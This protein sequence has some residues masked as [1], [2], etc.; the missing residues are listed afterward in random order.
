[1]P[2][3]SNLAKP[4]ATVL[5]TD[6]IFNSSEGFTSGNKFYSVNPAARWR[7]FPSRHNKEGGVLNFVD[8]HSAYYRQSKIKDQQ[9][10]GNEPLLPDVIW[11]PPYRLKYP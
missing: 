5:L 2:K 3:V 10:D 6:S 11:N 9:T 4:S 7:A 8:G 1:M